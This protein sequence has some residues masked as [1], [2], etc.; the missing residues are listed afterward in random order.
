MADETSRRSPQHD[1]DYDGA[2]KEALR[3]HLPQFMEKYFPD[4]HATID[5]SVESE[6]FDKELSQVLGQSGRRNQ[7]VD[8]LVKVR[9]LAGGEQWILLHL[10]IQTSYEDDF[11][12][13]VSLYNCG[14]R[15][16]FR[17]RVLTLVVLA[18]LRRDWQPNEDHFQLGGFES[19]LKIPTCKLIDKL[20]T[21]W[22][23]DNSLPVLV[24]RAQVEA[25]RTAGDAEARY[26]VKWLLVRSL[27]DMGYNAE[28]VRNI[29]RLIDWM[30]HLRVD[31]ERQFDQKLAD[32]EKEIQM[33]FVTSIERVAWSKAILT[34]LVEI[35]GSLPDDIDKRVQYLPFEQL[36]QLA[37]DL[38][39]FKTLEDL[40]HWLDEQ[41]SSEDSKT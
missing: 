28:R 30:M 2:W 35:C 23:D 33:P 25:L 4:E 24:A 12:E 41:A 26:Q 36:E 31:L 15:W 18:D 20:E 27:Y 7:Q 39:H 17:Q 13:R 34:S 32:F 40:Q 16:V 10:E 14:L 5:W 29:F 22:Q 6:W 37:K 1:S 19:R 11:A 21:Q 9:L 8:V 38:P 3:E